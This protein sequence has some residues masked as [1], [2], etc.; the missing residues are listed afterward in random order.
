MLHRF[1]HV[2]IRANPDGG[3][4]L[5]ALY[6]GLMPSPPP[7]SPPSGGSRKPPDLPPIP[8]LPSDS[9]SAALC[10]RIGRTKTIR[11]GKDR[12]KPPVPGGPIS[13]PS[14]PQLP[15]DLD[16]RPL[17]AEERQ[18]RARLEEYGEKAWPKELARRRKTVRGEPSEATLAKWREEFDQ[19]MEMYWKRNLA[20]LRRRKQPRP[21]AHKVPEA[22]PR[23]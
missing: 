10:D 6:S 23:E 22:K 2:E 14:G 21:N 13:P 15:P 18:L 11:P 20:A 8:A 5:T 4:I 3:V 19:R 17:T 16:P 9:L 7:G 12:P 1:E